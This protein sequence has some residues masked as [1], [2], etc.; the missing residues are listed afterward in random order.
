MS[1]F[2]TIVFHEFPVIPTV[3]VQFRMRV[4][5]PDPEKPDNSQ[6]LLQQPEVNRRLTLTRKFTPSMK[7]IVTVT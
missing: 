6:R 4:M 5:S 7:G 2:V 3:I 1:F